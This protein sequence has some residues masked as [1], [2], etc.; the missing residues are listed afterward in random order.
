VAEGIR[1]V[2]HLANEA[3]L[4]DLCRNQLVRTAPHG[5]ME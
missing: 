1:D 2:R 5:L 4:P 3:E